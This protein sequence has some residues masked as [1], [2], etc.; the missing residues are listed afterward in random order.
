MGD[1]SLESQ[2][3]LTE[4]TNKM[5]SHAESDLQAN[6]DLINQQ[7]NSQ[8]PP[9]A[10]K[11][12]LALA[13]D[14]YNQPAI[15]QSVSVL[16]QPPMKT[17]PNALDVAKEFSRQYYTVLNRCPEFLHRFY[18]TCSSMCR[19]DI[20][21]EYDQA[22][23]DSS[24]V[25]PMPES[26]VGQQC[27]K[28]AYERLNLINADPV[29]SNVD[30]VTI[31]PKMD[32]PVLITGTLHSNSFTQSFVLCR[33]S[34]DRQWS[35]QS[36]VFRYIS[37]PA[38]ESTRVSSN[39]TTDITKPTPAPLEMTE[40]SA[41]QTGTKAPMNTPLPKNPDMKP[42]I[43]KDENFHIVPEE[44]SGI[45][46]LQ[47]PPPPGLSIPENPTPEPE[48]F[49][50]SNYPKL[51]NSGN[52]AANNVNGW[53][54]LENSTTIEEKESTPV[55]IESDESG[56]VEVETPVKPVTGWAA[57]AKQNAGG[58]PQQAPI[59]QRISKPIQQVYV[60]KPKREV[61]DEGF[62][63][64]DGRKEIVRYPDDQQIF[65]GNLPTNCVESDIRHHFAKV[66]KV[67]EVRLN[68]AKQGRDKPQPAFA[69]V[70]FESK[71]II[72]K[73]LGNR[74]AYQDMTFNNASHR[75]NI[76]PKESTRDS[77]KSR[78]GGGY[79]SQGRGYY[80][81]E[82]QGFSSRRY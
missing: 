25:P 6:S 40:P 42:L 44:N 62:V 12:N 73:I 77:R 19:S 32:I 46:H 70:V 58:T 16:N 48:S 68:P 67:L 61:R 9:A 55:K 79:R 15:N 2:V 4:T 10:I 26:F 65:V 47:G 37:V 66:A 52:L 57:M 64:K 33:G 18:G 41:F 23:G 29:I 27:I 75:I 82:R 31:Y 28:M 7:N 71:E 14:I 50:E 22:H 1:S 60:Q 20:L 3:E 76:E 36:D 63:K 13:S 72:I 17:G 51:G 34:S 69:F 56:A 21:S 35:I 54:K 43:P 78:D 39:E 38:I 53:Q 11:P 59:A 49:S 8:Q 5:V 24:G 74:A 30:A 81:R 80:D 45:T